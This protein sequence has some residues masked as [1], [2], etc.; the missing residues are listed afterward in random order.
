MTTGPDDDLVARIAEIAVAAISRALL[1]F[2]PAIR[3]EIAASVSKEFSGEQVYI[4][5]ALDTQKAQR[6]EAMRADRAAG[7]SVRAIARK[8]HIC[9]TSVAEILKDNS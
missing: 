3:N 1:S 8:R 5:K 2:A 9:K 4:P 7:L 6:N